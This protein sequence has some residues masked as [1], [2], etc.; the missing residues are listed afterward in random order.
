MKCN[1]KLKFRAYYK[2]DIERGNPMKFIQ[3][4]I[5]DELCFIYEDDYNAG[6][7][8]SFKYPFSAMFMDDDWIIEQWT[9]AY[10]VD[11]EVYVM[12]EK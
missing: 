12:V 2:L 11:E 1:M 3:K 8:S 6:E 7:P 9:G 4:V 5:D 10:D